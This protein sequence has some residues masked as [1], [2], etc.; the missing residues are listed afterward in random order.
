MVK[1]DPSN[2]KA[3]PLDVWLIETV[4]KSLK[5]LDTG[6]IGS[7]LRMLSFNQYIM[8]ARKKAEMIFHGAI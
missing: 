5:K 1:I 2:R 4:M 3:T 8:P 7:C 6:S